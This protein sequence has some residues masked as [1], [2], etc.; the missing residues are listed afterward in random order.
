MLPTNSHAFSTRDSRPSSAKSFALSRSCFSIIGPPPRAAFL[1]GIGVK[2][3]WLQIDSLETIAQDGMMRPCFVK[4]TYSLVLGP[5]SSVLGPWGTGHRAQEVTPLQQ[6][7]HARS[8]IITCVTRQ[9]DRS[10]RSWKRRPVL[11]L[12]SAASA[13]GQWMHALSPLVH[14]TVRASVRRPTSNLS[15]SS[16]STARVRQLMRTVHIPDRASPTSVFATI[17]V[18]IQMLPF[19]NTSSPP[20][21]PKPN[22]DSVLRRSPT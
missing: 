1:S 10:G 7:Q 20:P 18:Q 8:G 2:I 15:R 16:L 4:S 11:S 3:D 12:A 22:H 6:R 13:L 14:D 21:S 17:N 5:R 19:P 9:M